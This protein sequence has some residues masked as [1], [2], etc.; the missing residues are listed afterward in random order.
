MTVLGRGEPSCSALTAEGAM[1]S[2]E[3]EVRRPRLKVGGMRGAEDEEEEEEGGN[4]MGGAGAGA[5]GGDW[6]ASMGT[7]A[8]DGAAGAAEAEE[9]EEEPKGSELKREARCVGE[10]MPGATPP[11]S[12]SLGPS[13]WLTAGKSERVVPTNC[14]RCSSSLALNQLAQNWS[15]SA[16]RARATSRLRSLSR[17]V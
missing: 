11:K 17:A 14:R 9:E 4:W 3:T 12:R 15:G 2:A 1:L 7:G 6:E 16:G 8:E 10:A 13:D 5:E